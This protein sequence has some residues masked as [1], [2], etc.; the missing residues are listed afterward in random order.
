MHPSQFLSILAVVTSG[1]LAL[2]AV[3]F[4]AL[5]GFSVQQVPVGKRIKNGPKS[6]MD[7]LAKYGAHASAD[8]VSGAQAVEN[9]L[10]G[11][12]I[13]K[14]TQTGMVINSPQT[15]DASYLIPV[16]VG[17]PAQ[18]L[19]L[20][21]DSGSADLWV[22]SSE[23]PASESSGHSIYTPSKS[24]TSVQKTGYTW[25]ITYEDGS[26]ADGN[27][28]SDKVVVGGATATSQAVEAA[29]SVSSSF[30]SDTNNDGLI[31]LAMSSINT[32]K[33]NAQTTFLDTIKSTLPA[34]L[35]T[36][37]LK[38][39]APGHYD[40]GYINSS[41]YTG[42]IYYA[43]ISTARGFWEFNAGAYY[44]GTAA[45]PAL[46]DSIADTGTSIILAPTSVINN[47]YA[48]VSKAQ[49]NSQ[50]GGVIFPCSDTLPTFSVT[51]GG[52]KRTVPGAYLNYVQVGTINSV[53][54][55]YGA[56]QSNNGLPFTILGDSFLKS[57]FVVFDEGNTRIG[58]AT[59]A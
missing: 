38:H 6:V 57:Q 18:T 12:L 4:Q 47:Y 41:S 15:N 59:Q 26:G 16:S 53:P 37:T 17:T 23:L 48:Q 25:N 56:L 36:C 43:P 28:F 51:I 39:Q 14:R 5:T 21:L 35:F 46:N 50:V 9:A 2:P 44:V 32:V 13:S 31:G 29:T 58:F 1:A 34:D 11:K 27:V 22:F 19:M 54:Y 3:D 30:Q 33:P 7:T 8:L 24:T 42:S 45:Y 20:D 40:F 52:S 49:Y 55:C 10:L